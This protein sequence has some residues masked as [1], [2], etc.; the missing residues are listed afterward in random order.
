MEEFL[1][2]DESFTSLKGGFLN[3]HAPPVATKIMSSQLPQNDYFNSASSPT[4]Q[5]AGL[6]SRPQNMSIRVSDLLSSREHSMSSRD[7]TPSPQSND[8]S[9]LVSPA[10]SRIQARLS[11]PT[12]LASPM[13]HRACT[14]VTEIEDRMTPIGESSITER[15]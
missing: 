2:R 12:R 3:Y 4:P 6:T 15:L 1:F 10:S 14:P 8:R 7:T 13:L 5:A 9:M 11:S